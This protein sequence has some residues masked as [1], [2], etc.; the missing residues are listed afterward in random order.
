MST[1]LVANFMCFPA[2]KNFE[3]WLRFDKV[4]ETLKVGTFFEHSVV[5]AT[6]IDEL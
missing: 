5:I 6:Y 3:N 1:G 2:V 4:T